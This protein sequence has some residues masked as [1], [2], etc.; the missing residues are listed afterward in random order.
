MGLIVEEVSNVVG[1]SRCLAHTIASFEI[2]LIVSDIDR[3]I[4]VVPDSKSMS[5]VEYK[6]AYVVHCAIPKHSLAIHFVVLPKS[7]IY[8]SN[9]L[10]NTDPKAMSIAIKVGTCIH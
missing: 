4:Y 9:F 10:A 2:L 5:I 7:N 8:L 6:V 1:S 3:P